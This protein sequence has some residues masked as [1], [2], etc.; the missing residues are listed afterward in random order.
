MD[1]PFSFAIITDLHLAGEGWDGPGCLEWFIQWV[2]DRDDID[3]VLCLGD[4]IFG[5]PAPPAQQSLADLQDA[6]ARMRRPVHVLYGNNDP[7]LCDTEVY[8][9][10]WGARDRTFEHKG[11]LFVVM[12]DNL[13]HVRGHGHE[14]YIRDEQWDWLDAQLRDARGRGLRHIF[15]AAHVPPAG[16]NWIHPG[17]FL[18]KTTDHR[19]RAVCREYAITAAFFGHIHHGDVWHMDGT[20]VVVTPSLCVNFVPPSPPA[21]DQLKPNGYFRTVHV[22]AQGIAHEMHEVGCGSART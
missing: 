22:S 6:F 8:E 10:I 11:C 20:E 19:L 4:L 2:K 14:G 13:A 7:K 18:R 16:P 15:F 17:M 3:F 9:G 12:W 1:K 21:K 5:L